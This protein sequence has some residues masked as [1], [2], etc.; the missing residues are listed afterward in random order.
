MTE[1][2]RRESGEITTGT[3]G[4]MEAMIALAEKGTVSVEVMERMLDMQERILERDARMAF[5]AALARFQAECPQIKKSKTA[6]IV[7]KGGG[8]YSYKYAPLDEITRTVTPILHKHGFSYTWNSEETGNGVRAVFILRHVDGHTEESSFLALTD[9]SASMSAA[10]KGGAAATYARRQS[11]EMG[12][13]LSTSDDVDGADGT[14]GNAPVAPKVGAKVG[15]EL[16]A[17]AEKSGVNVPEM[18]R[19]YEVE[20]FADMEP[21]QAKHARAVMESRLRKAEA[22]GS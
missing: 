2:A 1:I 16:Q 19:F 7:M 10:Q 4:P 13:G 8:A 3:G 12:L 22:A 18:F 5:I 6:K 20:S 15:A 9:T 11:M 14:T 21:D 17:L